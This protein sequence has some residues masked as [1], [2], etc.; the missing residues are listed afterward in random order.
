MNR[1]NGR[2][3]LLLA[4]PNLAHGDYNILKLVEAAGGEIV[5]EE[6]CEGIRYYWQHVENNGDP[7]LSPARSYL[8]D[9]IPCAFMR[10][11]IKKK[12]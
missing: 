7:M 12:A 4:G 8:R 3:R 1:K 10:D 5:I 6:I 11:S 9:R 2:P